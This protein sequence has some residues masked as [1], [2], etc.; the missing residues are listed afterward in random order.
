MKDLTVD[1]LMVLY[2]A[3]DNGN[4]VQF[5]IKTLIYLEKKIQKLNNIVV[6]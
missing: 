5:L 3:L 4:R 1:L 2:W 6:K